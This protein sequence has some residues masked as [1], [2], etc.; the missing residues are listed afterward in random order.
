MS[1]TPETAKAE[2]KVGR[3][4]HEATARNRIIV[5]IM[6]AHGIPHH[7]IGHAIGIDPTTLRRHYKEELRDARLKVEAAM[8]VAVVQAAR[9]G[10]WGAAKYWLQTHGSPDWKVSEHRTIDGHLDLTD[11]TTDELERRRAELE[12]LRLT[13]DR[14]RDL[15]A[16]LPD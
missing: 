6:H 15:E 9:N 8:G 4:K 7:I 16:T 1:D 3:P 10:N 12:R 5:Q 11:T 2:R 13:G 14:A